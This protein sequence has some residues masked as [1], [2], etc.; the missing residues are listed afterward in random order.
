MSESNLINK[1]GFDIEKGIASGPPEHIIERINLNLAA[2]GQPI[3]GQKESF[4]ALMM[5]QNLVAHFRA[6]NELMKDGLRPPVDL[7]IEK[8]LAGYLSELEEGTVHLPG[9]TYNLSQHGIARVLSLPADA[10][11]F[12]NDIIESYRLENGVL[13]NPVNDRRTTKGVFHVAEGGL[14]V[15]NDK[16][17]VPKVAFARLLKAALNPPA[18]LTLLPFTST[19]KQ[20]AHT[21]VSLLLRPVVCPEVPGFIP[22]K[23]M[24]IRFFAPGSMAA[25]LDFVESIFGNAG[26]PFLSEN[27]AGL[28][29]DHWSGHTGCVILAPHIKTLTK[30]ELGLPNIK[31]A[32]ERHKRDG[33]CWE[34]EDEL[35][36]DGGAFKITARTEDGVV[37]T[38]IADN[39]FGYC[40]KEVKT[41]IGFSANL[42]GLS[43]EEHAG[44]TLAFSSYDL[45]EDFRLSNYIEEEVRSFASVLEDYGDQM[46]LQPEGYAVD[47]HHSCLVYLPENAVFSLPNQNITW[48]SEGKESSIKL[49]ASKVYMY[50]N[51]YKVRL[52]KP[53]EG[54]RWRL[55]GTVPEGTNCHKPCTV[56]GGGKSEI[57][58]SIGDAIIHAPFYIGNLKK[59]FDA[60]ERILKADYRE[61]FKDASKMAKDSRAILSS[62][63]SLGSVIKLLT[64]HPEYTE[65]HNAFVRNIPTHIK[66]LVLLLKR[67]YKEDWGKDWR[68]RFSVN[69]INGISGHELKYRDNKVITSYLRVGYDDAD[70][71]RVFSLRKDFFPAAKIQTEDDIS[72]SVVVPWEN[73]P[74][75][76]GRSQGG[77][78]AKVLI[79]CEHRLFQRPDDAIVRGYD[80]KTEE[81][82]SRPYNFFSNYAPLKKDDVQEMVDDAV[83]FDYFTEPMKSLLLNFV[84]KP[85]GTEYV[86][87]SSNPRIVDGTPTKNPRYLQNVGTL[88]D[89]LSTYLAEMGVRFKRK[90]KKDEAVLYPVNGFLPGR[91]NNPPEGPIRSLAVFNP[92]H[93]LPLPEAF[94]EFTSSMT[95][96][97]PSTTGAGSEG[98]LTKAP[99][100]ALL[101]ITD[102]NNALVAAILTGLNPFITAAGYVGPNFRVD[103]DISLLVPEIWCR[104]RRYE[105]DP[106]WLIENGF[107]E[108]VPEYEHNGEKIPTGLLGY[109]INQ[110]FVNYF[111]GRIFTSPEMLFSEAMLKPE[112][113]SMEIFADGMDNI[114]TTHRVVAEN[115]FTDGSI[116]QAIPPMKALLHIMREGNYEGKTLEDAEIRDLF[117]AESVL[118][119]DWYADRIVAKQVVE[120]G[121]W[122]RVMEYLNSYGLTLNSL[123]ALKKTVEERINAAGSDDYLKSLRGTIGRDTG[124]PVAG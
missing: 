23:R 83:R 117:T 114:L 109:R 122:K 44:G 123:P 71:W 57:S 58:K 35:Y 124:I 110:A 51:G 42:Y 79:N 34:K 115:Y 36:N 113:Q 46:D 68:E 4:P 85:D 60:V 78:G 98:A 92:I 12:K 62:K 9:K 39:Y 5:S 29:V 76:P 72:A 8:F 99:F 17:S 33:M 87:S 67:F 55:I 7:R 49:L 104:M 107:L 31:D 56:S 120:I 73:I 53:A 13:H 18:D 80:K 28:D 91:R 82:M 77:V 65:A 97:S 41:Q 16:K 93:Y 84:K 19:Q 3:F 95:G 59:D 37:V 101:P 50:P 2:L 66:E 1:I 70:A 75:Q 121:H 47:K 100:N 40:K 25:N 63:R 81:D 88:E 111:L 64:P 86:V 21:W 103:H 6:K 102:M 54:R 112:Q 38:V 94:M 119:S 22:E 20:K 96:K 48:E 90:L 26:D 32:T 105:R 11:S 52:V 45:G 116:D 106:K 69:I 74:G 43:E 108:P 10:D 89:P 61:R 24:E 14:P 27:D 15:P 118:N 30:K